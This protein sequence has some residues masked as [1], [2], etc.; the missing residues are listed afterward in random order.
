M[1]LRD[2]LVV[3]DGSARSDVALGAALGVARHHDA[4]VSC[5]CPLELLYVSSVGV[6]LVGDPK[7]LAPQM[8]ANRFGA[9][10]LEKARS[11]ETDFYERLER[12]GV[13]GDWQ[14]SEGLAV[15]DVARRA[16]RADLLVLGQPAPD[17]PLTPMAHHLA[18]A[19][20]INSGRP[21]LFVPFAGHFTSIG[22]NVLLEWNETREAARSAHDALLLIEPTAAVTVLTIERRSL[23][24]T[25]REIPSADIAEHLA[26][27]GLRVSAASTVTDACISDADVLLAYASDNGA[28][29]LVV[30]GYEHSR[31]RELRD[32]MTLPVL[33]SH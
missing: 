6:S 25:P 7:A 16:L 28:D 10:V 8:G 15:D 27:H 19:A 30:G 13:Q 3:H 33:M 26:R 14:I 18:E 11:I 29:L 17:H 12:N 31:T 9:Q 5:F 21:L 4:R 2:L 23:P 20:L 22:T 24:G 32:H 1:R